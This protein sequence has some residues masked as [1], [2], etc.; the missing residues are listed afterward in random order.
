[1]APDKSHI[2]AYVHILVFFGQKSAGSA[3]GSAGMKRLRAEGK[4]AA[5]NKADSHSKVA[6]AMAL[7]STSQ[8]SART[9]HHGNQQDGGEAAWSAYS[10]ATMNMCKS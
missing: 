4:S 8:R 1:M 3:F 10:P 2:R 5:R 9:H 7:F 6:N